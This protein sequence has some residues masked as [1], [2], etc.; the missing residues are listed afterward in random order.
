MMTIGGGGGEGGIT[1]LWLTT[2]RGFLKSRRCFGL[3]RSNDRGREG[4]E[5]E[6][7]KRGGQH[8]GR[9]GQFPIVFLYM[10]QSPDPATPACL[11]FLKAGQSHPSYFAC[12]PFPFPPSLPLFVCV[13]VCPLYTKPY[14][15]HHLT[16]CAVI[17][18]MRTCTN[19]YIPIHTHTYIHTSFD[20][21]DECTLKASSLKWF[22]IT[23]EG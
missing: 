13:W 22:S 10:C 1:Q 21:L 14:L 6:R 11:H 3:E 20:T 16:L 9:W 7:G 15:G 17:R 2:R 18:T 23:A 8:G 4:E 19:M 12:A 5:C